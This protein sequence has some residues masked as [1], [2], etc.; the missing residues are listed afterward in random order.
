MKHYFVPLFTTPGAESSFL[1]ANAVDIARHQGATI[2][3]CAFEIAGREYT[4][5]AASLA[6]I[7]AVMRQAELW[8]EEQ[9]HALTKAVEA[10]AAQAGIDA[11]A[12]HHKVVESFL[13]EAVM[14]RARYFDLTIMEVSAFSRPAVE[15]ALLGSGR[16]LLLYPQ[17]RRLGRFDHIA[18]AWDGGRAAS[19]AL[20]DAGDILPKAIKITLLSVIDEKP[21]SNFR[22]PDIGDLLRIKGFEVDFR[23]LR[24][25]GASIG[26]LLQESAIES[27]ADLLVAGGFGHSRLREFV[28]GGVTRSL[29]SGL[30]LPVLMSH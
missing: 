3:S 29:L 14:E 11:V 18:V 10:A 9:G 6:E 24:A 23:Q 17:K 2:Y 4:D 26:E 20:A 5:T 27:G 19:R 16:P 25:D 1:I 30:K 12:D 8:S 7:D 22:H 15:A 13:S 28:L 21:L